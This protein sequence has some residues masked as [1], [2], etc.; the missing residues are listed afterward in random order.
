[1]S[2]RDFSLWDDERPGFMHI[3]GSLML[4]VKI[5]ER[6]LDWGSSKPSV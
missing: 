1:M 3:F 6:G 5:A 4:K 2:G